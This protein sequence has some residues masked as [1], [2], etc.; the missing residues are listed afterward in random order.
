MYFAFIF[1]VPYKHPRLD[2]SAV[3][4]I[5]HNDGNISLNTTI[6]H[7]SVEVDI[8]IDLPDLPDAGKLSNMDPN[9]SSFESVDEQMKESY[10][11]NMYTLLYFKQRKTFN[12]PKLYETFLYLKYILQKNYFRTP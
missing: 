3:P 11:Q 9:C 4:S 10:I 12:T 2:A 8:L 1:K 7:P 5:F 6:E